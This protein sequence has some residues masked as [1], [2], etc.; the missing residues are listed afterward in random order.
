[1]SLRFR[2]WH[3]F[4]EVELAV[5]IRLVLALLVMVMQMTAMP[6]AAM[7]AAAMPALPVAAIPAGVERQLE[8]VKL[9]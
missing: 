2:S 3:V 1:V 9:W 8:L 4:S 7:P 5:A 6:V